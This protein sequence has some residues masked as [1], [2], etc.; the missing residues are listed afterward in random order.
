MIISAVAA[1]AFASLDTDAKQK[2]TAVS[3]FKNGYSFIARETNIP[4]SGDYTVDEPPLAAHGT[5]WHLPSEGISIKRTASTT[6]DVTTNATV[7]SI[8]SMIELNIGSPATVDFLDLPS[9]TGTLMQSIGDQLVVKTPEGVVF[10]SR[11]RIKRLIFQKDPKFQMPIKSSKRVM[12]LEVEAKQPGTINT[13]GLEHGLM[14]VPAYAI[15][16]TDPKQLTLVAKAT[17]INELGDLDNVDASFITGF[18]NVQFRNVPDPLTNPASL[19]QMLGMLVGVSFDKTDNSLITQNAAPAR[20]AESYG[21]APDFTGGFIPTG[22]GTQMEDLFFYKLSGITLKKG[23]RAAYTLFTS[24]APYQHLYTWDVVR[25]P[26]SYQAE[27]MAHNDAQLQDVWHSLTFKNSSG[28]PFTTAVASTFQNGQIL[29]QDLM[30]YTTAGAEAEVRITKALDIRSEA[31]EEEISRDRASLRL[32]SG[33][34]Y[35]LL[36][37]KGTL[38]AKNNRGESARM[39]ISLSY[40]GDPVSADGNPKVIKGT[41]GLGEL[42]PLTSLEWRPEVSAGKTLNLTYTYKMYVR[43]P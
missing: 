28:K 8:D 37:V 17:V 18:P 15:D 25:L 2:I 20:D 35:D 41:K 29:G 22:E 4:T 7:G 34:T 31:I 24:K 12:K 40:D 14:W 16:I 5:F 43:T 30:R 23:D 38:T 11:A 39:R 33:N 21:R 27:R 36:T 3:M 26:Y 42:N 1:F 32:P 19:D 9:L 10:V 13:V 6:I